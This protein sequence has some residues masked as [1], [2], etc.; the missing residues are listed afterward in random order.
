MKIIERP[1][2]GIDKEKIQKKYPQATLIRNYFSTI[3]TAAIVLTPSCSSLPVQQTQESHQSA[4]DTPDDNVKIS[5]ELEALLEHQ[6]TDDEREI[7]D[8]ILQNWKKVKPLITRFNKDYQN[9]DF[10]KMGAEEFNNVALEISALIKMRDQCHDAMRE[11]YIVAGQQNQY[12]LLAA[13]E[14]LKN[15][16]IMP[17]SMLL[18]F[19]DL[20]INFLMEQQARKEST[21]K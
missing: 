6:L 3:L 16:E 13:M 12:A 15:D 10:S 1:K 8:E 11:T 19:N 4:A 5:P 14:Q 20:Y 2:R 17:H 7:F 18:D 21:T 9:K